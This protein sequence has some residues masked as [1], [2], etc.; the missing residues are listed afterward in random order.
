MTWEIPLNRQWLN[1][2]YNHGYNILNSGILGKIFEL[3]GEHGMALKYICR[4]CQLMIGE[5][6]NDLVSE[7]R[8]GF[9]F[10][11]PEERSDIIS[12]SLNGD[13]TVKVVCD[14]CEAALMAHPELSLVGS[15]LQ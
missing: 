13:A 9:H 5:I 8:L 14:D 7:F 11:T 10:L 12:Y 6:K 1:S 2:T 3:G 15:P 4:H